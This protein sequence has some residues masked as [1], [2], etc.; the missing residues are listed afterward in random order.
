M[1]FIGGDFLSITP[2][3][4]NWAMV[5]Q[6]FPVMFLF[7]PCAQYSSTG[8]SGKY[9]LGPGRW[10]FKP[11]ILLFECLTSFDFYATWDTT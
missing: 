6:K 2:A 7:R 9:I 3:F 5:L 4:I 8:L 10:F 1:V 11:K